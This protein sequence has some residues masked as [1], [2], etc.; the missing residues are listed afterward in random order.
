MPL[1]LKYIGISAFNGCQNLESIVIPGSIKDIE[2]RTFFDCSN[3]KNVTISSGIINIGELAF[4]K[5]VSITDIV[6]PG[7]ESITVLP[8]NKKYHSAG[9]CII[10][11]AKNKTIFKYKYTAEG[12]AS[13][14]VYFF[15]IKQLRSIIYYVF[16]F[17]SKFLRA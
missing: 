5:C 2:D 15:T 16:R 11:T 7:L 13:S 6:I 9:N 10:E 8:G 14:A 1:G 17:P 12:K 4:G 3:L